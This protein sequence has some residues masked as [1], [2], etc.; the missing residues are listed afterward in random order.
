MKGSRAE[1][2]V[3]LGGGRITSAL[4]AGLRSSGYEQDWKHQAADHCNQP[5]SGCATR[6]IARPLGTARTLGASD[7]ESSMPGRA[8]PHSYHV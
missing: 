6:E 5:G 1:A 8:R 2:T 3:F 4:I 7:A